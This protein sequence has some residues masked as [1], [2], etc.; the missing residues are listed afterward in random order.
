[1]A[2]KT[3]Y[4]P[5]NKS[6]Y[7]GN[8]NNVICRSL[9]ERRVCKYLDEN[10]NILRWGSEELSIPYISPID[11]KVHKYFPDFIIEK[12]NKNKEIETIIIEVKPKKQ[13]TPPK[14]K[15]NKKSYLRECITYETNLAKWNAA[16]EYCTVHNYKFIILTEKD[17]FP[18]TYT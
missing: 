7:M 3:K 16:G 10:T 9:W 14:K 15:S 1:M 2:Y 18:N 13:T 17:I 6:K 11:G 8:V 12:I 4:N 5:K